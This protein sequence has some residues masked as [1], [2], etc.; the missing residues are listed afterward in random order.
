MAHL[1]VYRASAGSGKTYA[2]ALGFIKHLV[3]NPYAYRRILAVTFTN[4]ATREMKSRIVSELNKLATGEQTTYLDILSASCRLSPEEI[5]VRAHKA[6]NLILHDFSRFT[7]ETIDKFFHRVLKSFAREI[8]IQSGFNLELDVTRIM[9]ESVDDMLFHLSENDSLKEWLIRFAETKI[10]EGKSWNF[11]FD[12]LNTGQEI[13]KEKFKLFSKQLITKLSDKVLLKKYITDLHNIINHFEKVLQDLGKKGL[14]LMAQYDLE[15]EDF[16][17]GR[18]GFA[19]HFR[20]LAEKSEFNPVPR[21]RSALDDITSWYSKASE[22]KEI[23]HEVYENGLNRILVDSIRFY[24]ANSEDYETSVSLARFIYTLGVLTDLSKQVRDY[25]HEKNLFLITDVAGF[26]KEIIEGND[27][28]FIYEKTGNIFQYFMIDEFQDTSWIQWENFRPLL[29]NS[30][31]ENH[32][33][34]LAGDVKQSIYRWRNSDWKI[35]SEQLN[36]DFQDEWLDNRHLN[37]NWRS[38]ENIV[39]FNN[40]FFKEA[41][42]SLEHQFMDK[43][44]E[45]AFEDER[46]RNL[47]GGIIRA[48]EDTVQQ[49]PDSE[50]KSGG[51]ISMKFFTENEKDWREYVNNQLPLLVHNLLDKGYNPGDITILVRNNKDGR[52]VV[53]RMLSRKLPGNHTKHKY[54]IISNESL[55]L[56]NSPA[57]L[58]IVAVLQ[59]LMDSGDRIN[60]AFMLS[61]YNRCFNRDF[62]SQQGFLDIITKDNRSLQ[63]L[64]DKS[65]PKEFTEKLLFLSQL[66]LYELIEQVVRIFKLNKFESEIP[67]I[68]AFQDKVIEFSKNEVADLHYFLEWWKNEG[69]KETISVSDQQNAVRVL[70][71]HKAKGLE[72]PV[73]IIPYCN[74]YLDHKPSMQNI[75]WCEPGREPFRTLDLVPVNYSSNLAK[76]IFKGDYYTEKFHAYV[77]NLNLLYVSFTRAI[78]KLFVFAPVGTKDSMKHAGDLLYRIVREQIPNGEKGPGKHH[79]FIMESNWNEEKKEFTA[80]S[81]SIAGEDR[82]KALSKTT[83]LS[84]YPSDLPDNRLRLNL[85]K[86]DYF[87]L[88]DESKK[89]RIN[90]GNLM[91]ELFESIITGEDVDKAVSRLLIKGKIPDNEVEKLSKEVT[92]KV[93]NPLVSDWYNK[94]WDVKTEA[95]ILIKNDKIRRPDR[96]LVKGNRAIVVDYKFGDVEKGSY[97]VQIRKYMKH[98]AAMGYTD[99]KG[100]IWY[101][102]LEKKV[103]VF[104]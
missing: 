88:D 25:C 68:Q 21:A 17:Y 61:E 101:V 29:A 57:I 54:E 84:G 30:L 32:D 34:M 13:F 47:Q 42:A 18:N 44:D 8:G 81:D 60:K 91:H 14:V 46:I 3:E 82:W 63:D 74:W 26:L 97:K 100:F 38:R 80:G 36:V 96:V 93:S 33:C 103:E 45:T 16:K 37:T 77:D 19:N 10:E 87:L 70:T 53:T 5:Q 20:K 39:W 71:I 65:F 15:I 95:D 75:L 56:E 28:P 59:Y 90:H 12:I 104:L 89:A 94:S 66:P 99:V 23:I 79:S 55:F 35:L 11:K 58:F 51:Y 6:L 78:D 69:P 76:T 22:K 52:E 27:A 102:S 31:A 9:R 24:D 43:L 41:S 62:T 85:H 50:N 72:Y 2:L 64:I 98:L 86:S 92:E 7:V 48:Y 49:I 4:K 40:M 73:I 1:S 83:K 67:F